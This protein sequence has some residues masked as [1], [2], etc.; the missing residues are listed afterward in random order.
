MD[1][2]KVPQHPRTVVV[3][4][5]LTAELDGDVA[6]HGDGAGVIVDVGGGAGGF[7]VPLAAAGWHVT[8]VDPS[9][10]ALAALLRRA[11]DAG[12]GE[13][14]AAVQGDADA[15]AELVEPGSARLVLCHSVLEMVDAPQAAVDAIAAILA[16]GGAASLLVANRAGAVL[17]RAAAGHLGAAA[18]LLAD[19]H[20]R[21][22]E[23]DTLR[24]R[25]DPDTLNRLV[26]RS[27][28]RV[29]R[30]HGVQVV[31]EVAGSSSREVEAGALQAGLDLEL[32]AAA[33]SPYRD[34]AAGLHVLARKPQSE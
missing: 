32:A 13:R 14:V 8:V 6:Q 24:R 12:V 29:E 15:L 28:L 10:N 33:K 25:F 30:R 22:G 31:P 11:G 3:W 20:G 7:A 27:R 1:W 18:A 16:P 21:A 23:H 34:F 2:L 4:T 26:E 17:A 19:P 5:E 9:P